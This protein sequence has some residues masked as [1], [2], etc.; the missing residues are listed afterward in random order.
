MKQE[1]SS[2]SKTSLG[3]SLI[4]LVVVIGILILITGGGIASLISFNEKQQVLNGSKELQSYL[5]T[6]QTL[7]RV[8]EVPDGCGTLTGYKVVSSGVAFSKEIKVLAACS[9]GD[10]EKS[11]FLLPETTTLSSDINI[12]FLGLHGGVTGAAT[13]EVVGASDRTYT[14]EVTQGGEIT[15]GEFL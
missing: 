6:A 15:Q 13:V 5:R 12:S 3:F 8:G 11:S 9:S 7:A 4:E 1:Q 2:F 10:I 14:F